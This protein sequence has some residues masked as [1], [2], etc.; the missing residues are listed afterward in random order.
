MVNLREYLTAADLAFVREAVAYT[1]SAYDCPEERSLAALESLHASATAAPD[2]LEIS[3]FELFA[4]IRTTQ[5]YVKDMDELGSHEDLVVS[6]NAV[7]GKLVIAGTRGAKFQ[8]SNS[9]EP[10]EE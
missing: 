5:V 9:P 7:I 6:G 1:L 3:T 8:V 2:P 4:A 10:L